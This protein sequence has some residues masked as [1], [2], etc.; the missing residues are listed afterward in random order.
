MRVICSVL[1]T[2]SRLGPIPMYAYPS[3]P[4]DLTYAERPPVLI[5]GSSAQALGKAART[6]E[7]SGLRVADKVLLAG[8]IDRIERQVSATA[9]WV[10]LDGEAE[11]GCEALLQR[12][13]RDAAAGRYGAVVAAPSELI[14]IV[15]A[16]IQDSNVELVI[17]G[18]DSDRATALAIALATAAS[19]VRLSDIAADRSAARLRQLSEEVG[20][21]ASTLAR[22]STGPG[23]ATQPAPVIGAEEAPQV[24][25]DLI[26]SVIRARRLRARYF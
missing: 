1:G 19:P 22:L 12:V 21:I 8:A 11:A 17:E 2:S 23:A 6:I 3:E 16:Q 5:A 26:R 10:E 4:T 14:D 25:A 13:D 18:D 9:L 7:A 20:R 24:S 15:T